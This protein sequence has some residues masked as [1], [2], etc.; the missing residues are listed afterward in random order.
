M[1]N[2][3]NSFLEYLKIELNYSDKTVISYEMSINKYNEYIIKNNIDY[4]NVNRDEARGYLKY[5]D[6][7]NYKNTSIARD[8]SALRGFYKF[9]IRNKKTLKNI[10]NSINNPKKEKKL[11]NYLTEIEVDKML[12]FDKL[13]GY[14]RSVYTTRDRLIISLLYDTGCRCSELVGIKLNDID[15]ENN[16]IRILGKGSKE[17]IVYFGEYTKEDIKNYLLDREVLLN[18]KKSSYLLVSSEEVSITTRRIA[19]I[20]NDIAFLA[21]VKSKVTP[22]VIRH[23]FATHMLNHGGDLRGVQEMLGHESLS[24]TQIYTHVS[25]EWLRNTYLKAKKR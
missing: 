6:N 15:N 8:L 2:D 5:L 12:D 24:T 19:Q 22:H 4:L 10:W 17:R 25:K 18:G 13:S 23:T 11:P 3:I 7:L 21:G 1:K 14:K 20:L 16:S 9:L